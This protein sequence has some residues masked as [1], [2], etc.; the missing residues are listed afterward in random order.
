MPADKGACT[1]VVIRAFRAAGYD[2]Q[3]LIHEDM[4][5]HFS[6]A[7]RRSKAS[8]APTQYRPPPRAEPDCFLSQKWQGA[9]ARHDR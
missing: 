3:R 5:A 1:D 6:R 4:K 9:A 8:A 7:T 2:L